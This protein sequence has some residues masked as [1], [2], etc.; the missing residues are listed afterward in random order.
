M[1]RPCDMEEQV[2]THEGDDFLCW[3]W[4]WHL[5]S[6]WLQLWLFSFLVGALQDL[7]VTP[8]TLLLLRTDFDERKLKLRPD[9]FA[10]NSCMYF[11]FQLLKA[12]AEK[13]KVLLPKKHESALCMWNITPKAWRFHCVSFAILIKCLRLVVNQRLMLLHEFD[14]LF[15]E[16]CNS[17]CKVTVKHS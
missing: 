5:L 12:A 7:S 16:N 10:F 13:I 3:H 14:L 4:R 1:E 17:L 2:S 6:L 11:C 8:V 9:A 15:V